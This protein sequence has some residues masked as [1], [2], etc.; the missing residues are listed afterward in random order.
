M[1]WIYKYIISYSKNEF[2]ASNQRI[3]FSKLF[4]GCWLDCSIKLKSFLVRNHKFSLLPNNTL[5]Y[6]LL[7]KLVHRRV[8]RIIIPLVQVRC[9]LDL[10]LL[11]FF[12]FEY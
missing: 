3:L 2:I 8:P 1:N 6:K 11:D 12:S 4:F 7:T 10:K 5:L 9:F